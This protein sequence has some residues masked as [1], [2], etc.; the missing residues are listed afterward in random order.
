MKNLS[1]P[2]FYVK[3]KQPRVVRKTRCDALQ[4]MFCVNNK[5][6]VVRKTRC[7]ALQRLFCVNNKGSVVRNEKVHD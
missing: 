2:E 1:F 4:R 6:S 5:G 3:V 7:D